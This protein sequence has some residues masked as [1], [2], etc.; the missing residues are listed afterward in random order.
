MEKK[1]LILFLFVFLFGF[2]SAVDIGE[3]ERNNYGVVIDVPDV[4]IN[5]S[6]IPTVNS[7]DFWDDLDTPTDI[8]HSWL[9]DLA[10]SVAGHIMDITLDMAGND[11][12][13]VGDLTIGTLN[14]TGNF[15]YGDIYLD[16]FFSGPCSSGEAIQDIDEWGSFTC[17]NI[18]N[19]TSDDL[20][21]Y[22]N[23]S[24]TNANQ[25]INIGIYNLTS[26]WFNG[27]FNWTTAN[28]WSS[29]DG[30][31]FNFNDSKLSSIYYDATQT[32]MVTGTLDGGSLADTQ[33]SDASYDGRTLNFSE[34]SG[35]PA[36]D[37]RVNFT[38]VEDFSRGVMRYK[39]SNLVGDYP[40]RQLWN[41]N[42]NSW[43]N[44]ALF[45]V[46]EDFVTVTQP[47]FNNANYIQ[48]GLVQMRI[49]KSGSGKVNNHYYI[50]WVAMVGGYGVPSGQEIDPLS[51]HRDGNV[52][53]TDNWNT[54]NYNFS[55]NSTTLFV[56]S[57]LGR[58][59]IGTGN[60][61]QTL[62]INGNLK[63]DNT[64]FYTMI[65]SISTTANYYTEIGEFTL[66]N[67]AA[68]FDI[69]ITVPSNSYAQSK[70]YFIPASYHGTGGVWQKI[71]PVSTTGAFAG[72]DMDLEI[73]SNGPSTKFRLRRISGTTAGTAYI[74][75][76]KN[77]VD[78]DT[79]TESSG[80]GDAGAAAY[81]YV[82]PFKILYA[83]QIG[84]GINAYGPTALLQ[85]R[86]T[87]Q[88]RGSFD[89]G[90]W[91]GTGN[92][93]GAFFRTATN[94]GGN[95]PSAGEPA[96]ILGREGVGSQAY[97]N[98]VEFNVRRYEEDGVNARSALDIALTHGLGDAVGTDVMTLLSNGNVG[99]G[100]TIPTYPL[101]IIGNVSGISIW[102]DGNI[103][104]NDYIT[105][106]S[107]F[108]KSKN[109]WDYI[110]DADYYK[111]DNKI[112]HKKFYGYAGEFEIADMDRPVN[113]TQESEIC[114]EVFNDKMEK[115]QECYN[116]T[117]IVVDYPYVKIEGGVSLNKE[118]DVLRQ[119]VYEL[120]ERVKILEQ[121]C[122]R[123]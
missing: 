67:G 115:V 92:P 104:A 49:Y 74:T 76:M 44:L 8:S 14:I 6:L 106:T 96:L 110:K 114:E 85:V 80:Q 13:N 27:K 103:S 38:G 3:S 121:E 26:N 66:T 61:I 51:I 23:L 93:V 108:D 111:K 21:N 89:I 120:N 84:I 53:F 12:D 40:V 33:H 116:K 1:I 62:D 90:N 60:P 77:G 2:I 117:E 50:D 107:V 30:S 118:I 55:V 36:L 88:N 15:I 24:G 68:N 112:N 29:F 57:N 98:F 78:T 4:P 28:D 59:G 16:D 94:N 20:V 7:S 10:W 87:L 54:G 17:T 99:I 65:R 79:F 18:G 9:S 5:Y 52:Q 63:F 58:V 32:D 71:I 48:D 47:V 41:Y 101:T 22:L 102:S 73:N 42:T 56:D 100:T 37:L 64:I 45:V 43:D 86:D 72:Q 83:D 91:G 75:L 81:N 119:A 31:T 34:A 109:V 19:I 35:S 82:V 123:K 69:W 25:N 11:I 113:K 70:R 39:T 122:V 95:T 105:R 97:G 46:S